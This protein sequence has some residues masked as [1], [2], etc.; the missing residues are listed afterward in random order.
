MNHSFDFA[1]AFL[2]HSNKYLSLQTNSLD[3]KDQKVKICIQSKSEINPSFQKYQIFEKY[4]D[5][6]L[7]S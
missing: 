3:R 4:N 5:N 7:K 1:S 6:T 2:K